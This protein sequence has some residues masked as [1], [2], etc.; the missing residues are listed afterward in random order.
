MGK[1]E[2]GF[3][4]LINESRKTVKDCMQLDIDLD[5][6]Q[7]ELATTFEMIFALFMRFGHNSTSSKKPKESKHG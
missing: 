4:E 6:A 7:N 1:L 3:L 5:S 2:A